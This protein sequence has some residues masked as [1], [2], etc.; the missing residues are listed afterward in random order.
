MF[1]STDEE[2]NRTECDT[3][4]QEKNRRFKPTNKKR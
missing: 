4:K 3:A 1:E 2:L